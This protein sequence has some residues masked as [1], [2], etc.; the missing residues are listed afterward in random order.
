[1]I[2]FTVCIKYCVCTFALSACTLGSQFVQICLHLVSLLARLHSVLALW[3]RSLCKFYWYVVSLLAR[4]HSACTLGSQFARICLHV[5]SLLQF[6][7]ICL[8]VVSLLVRLNCMV[9]V[10]EHGPP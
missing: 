9:A 5:M 10:C 1:M 2:P 4:L 6:V 8:H 3:G 7:R